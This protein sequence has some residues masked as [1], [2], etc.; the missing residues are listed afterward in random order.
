VQIHRVNAEMVR[1]R[2]LEKMLNE[3]LANFKE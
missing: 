2:S 1:L 3:R